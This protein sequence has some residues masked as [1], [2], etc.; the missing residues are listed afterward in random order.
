MSNLNDPAMPTVESCEWATTLG[1]TKREAAAL[2]LRVPDSGDEELDA[3]IRKAR[4]LDM[5]TAA[6]QG[7]ISAS[8]DGDGNA[9]YDTSAVAR[10]SFAVARALMEEMEK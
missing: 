6:M 10:S 3:M 9:V 8:N 5:A 4:L 1:F 7:L 2:Q